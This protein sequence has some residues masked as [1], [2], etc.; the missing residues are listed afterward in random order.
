MNFETQTAYIFTVWYEVNKLI[1]F[2]F[3]FFKYSNNLVDV[4]RKGEFICEK[5][6]DKKHMK[7]AF[8]SLVWLIIRTVYCYSYNIPSWIRE[9]LNTTVTELWFC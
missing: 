1:Y 7:I 8:K 5:V 6:N 3:C 4:R 2:N 9:N